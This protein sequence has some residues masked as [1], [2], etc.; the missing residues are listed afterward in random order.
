MVRQPFSYSF[1][2]WV[3]NLT[4]PTHLKTDIPQAAQSM[5]RQPFSYSFASW[6]INLTHPTHRLYFL[7]TW[8][9]HGTR[10]LG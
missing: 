7:V 1:A 3:I 2:S 8:Q 10:G 4:H 5:V 6:V 9:S